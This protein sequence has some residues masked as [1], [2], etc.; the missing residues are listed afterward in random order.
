[1]EFRIDVSQSE[2]CGFILQDESIFNRGDQDHIGCAEEYFVDHAALRERLLTFQRSDETEFYVCTNLGAW[3]RLTLTENTRDFIRK[4]YCFTEEIENRIGCVFNDIEYETLVVRCGD[5]FYGDD[6]LGVDTIANSKKIEQTI[7]SIVEHHILPR[8]QLPI[9]VTSDNH[10]L[11]LVLAS[12]YGMLMLPHRSQ[13]G[14]FGNALPVAMDLCMLKRSRFNY[15]INHWATWWSGFSHYTSVI[16]RIPSMN[17][18][19]PM[20]SKEE[21]NRDGVLVLELTD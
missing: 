5:C 9:V 6:R 12:R 15:H 18:R 8:A 19:A 20:F 14:A 21:I 7:S 17:F 13:H 11:K 2:F 16:F 3:N 1:M 4:F 10:E